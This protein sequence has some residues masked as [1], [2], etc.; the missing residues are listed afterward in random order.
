MKVQVQASARRAPGLWRAGRYWSTTPTIVEVIDQD[1]DQGEAIGRRS[2]GMLQREPDLSVQVYAEPTPGKPWIDPDSA[3][4]QAFADL[5]EQV[6]R[7]ERER[8]EART[9]L[10][11]ALA[12][13]ADLES[14]DGAP[15]RKSTRKV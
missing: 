8:D 1:A 5:E 6:E 2:L 3:A 7:L 10:A 14:A 9:Q 15:K 4:S 13:I 12:K 11:E